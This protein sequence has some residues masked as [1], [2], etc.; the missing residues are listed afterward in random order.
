MENAQA[1]HVL[2]SSE[3]TDVS[4][5]EWG[6]GKHHLETK[7]NKL[8]IITNKII[9]HIGVRL[10]VS[11]CQKHNDLPFQVPIDGGGWQKLATD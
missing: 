2:Q 8:H 10:L 11:K 5:K 7:P 3:R 1:F 9:L 6:S 4:L